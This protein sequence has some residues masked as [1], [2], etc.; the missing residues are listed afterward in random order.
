VTAVCL[1]FLAATTSTVAGLRSELQEAIRKGR[2]P[3]SRL[4][5]S[6]RD[7]T[8]GQ[9]LFGLDSAAPLIPASNM[10]VI[11]TGAA[12]VSLGED[13]RFRTTMRIVDRGDGRPDLHLVGDGDPVFA[14]PDLLSFVT[15]KRPD[16]RV[17]KGLDSSAFLGAWAA[18]VR[19]A[20]VA[21]IESVVVD[22]RIFEPIGFHPK[23]PTDQFP[24]GY[25][26]EVHGF[27][28]HHN[29][30]QVWPAP[31]PGGTA[32]IARMSPDLA[33]LPIQNRTTSNRSAS[34]KHSFWIGRK[35][36]GNDLTLNGNVQVA[37][38]DPVTITLHGMP[39][40]LAD[41]FAV[42]LRSAGIEVGGARIAGPT[43]PTGQGRTIGPPVETPL[44][45]V[46]RR[47][48]TDSDNLSAE[49]LLKRVVHHE[50]KRPGSWADPSTD[51]PFRDSLAVGG[52]T[53]TVRNRFKSLEKT[54]CTVLCKTGFIRG[55]S[56]LSGIVVGP[57]GRTVAF[58]VLGN[59]LTAENAIGRM[60]ELQERVVLE[61][62]E[63][64]ASPRAALGG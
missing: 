6:V 20:N 27:N 12:L 21:A 47:C 46:L 28:F 62:A 22:S 29:V 23:W 61:I 5:V 58:S 56:C 33:F 31:R 59:D 44:A 11:T 63:D 34:A 2:P 15:W 41:L 19:D 13:F 3:G 50:T 48:N 32:T 25:C 18:A 4:G 53:G 24:E 55:V 60:K 51:R 35:Q 54:G 39:G 9:E 37:A 30:L 7:L 16:G 49:C 8:T 40:L 43:D 17:E 26:A 45:T 52:E 42:R 38:R 36:D 1:A 64:L 10:K 14:D 57:D